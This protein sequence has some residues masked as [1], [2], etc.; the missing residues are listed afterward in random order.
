MLTVS[1]PEFSSIRTGSA[2]GLYSLATSATEMPSSE[3]LASPS[4]AA[5]ALF[6]AASLLLEAGATGSTELDSDAC[7]SSPDAP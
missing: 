2:S 3:P 4:F 7:S 1:V 5:A 6:A